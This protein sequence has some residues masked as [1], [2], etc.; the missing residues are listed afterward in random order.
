MK[1]TELMRDFSF[2]KEVRGPGLMIGVETEF[3]CT[4]LVQE[5]IK[6]GLLF[7]VTHGNVIR[8]LPPYI[9]TEQDVDRAIVA[10][11]KITFCGTPR[12]PKRR[13]SFYSS[14]SRR[15]ASS[16]LTSLLTSCALPRLATNRASGV[17]TTIRFSTPTS[18]TVLLAS[19]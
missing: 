18:A 12:L 3:P 14:S 6:E 4:H 9:L 13:A 17:S 5:G 8:L 2:I 7:N 11:K 1:L 16:V 19:T 15:C 10:F